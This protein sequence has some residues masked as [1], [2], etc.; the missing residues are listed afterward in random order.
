MADDIVCEATYPHSPALVWQ[1][2]TRREALASWLMENTLGEP[3]AVGH[4]FRFTDRPRPFWDGVC[5]CEVVEATPERRLVLKWGLR[6][7]DGGTTVEWTLTPVGDSATR[8]QFRQSGLKGLSGWMMKKGMTRGWN[9][10]IGRALPYVLSV[11]GQGKVPSRDEV[12]AAS[13]SA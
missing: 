12:K 9:R 5:D 11:L 10:M 8:L 4:R 2:L 3:V 7:Q 1:A 6:P 13:T